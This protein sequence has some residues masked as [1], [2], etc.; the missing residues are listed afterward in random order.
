MEDGK[1]DYLLVDPISRLRMLRLI[2]EVMRGT[3]GAFPEAHLG[4][5]KTLRLRSDM[6][7]PIQ[8]DGEMYAPY[9]ADIRE[10]EVQIVPGA[11]QVIV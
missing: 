5:F 6:A 7:L 3:H 4:C 9:A 8:T 11:L 10:V 2:P 1:L